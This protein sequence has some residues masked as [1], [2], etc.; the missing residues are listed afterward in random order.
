[1]TL[2]ILGIFE[3]GVNGNVVAKAI[4]LM[5]IYEIKVRAQKKTFTRSVFRFGLAR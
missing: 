2:L 4:S 1:M 3:L 5:T